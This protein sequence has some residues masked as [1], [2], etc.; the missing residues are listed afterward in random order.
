MNCAELTLIK[1]TEKLKHLPQLK[2]ILKSVRK[3]CKNQKR[4]QESCTLNYVLINKEMESNGKS[5]L[6]IVIF[7]GIHFNSNYGEKMR[8]YQELFYIIFNQYLFE[9][10]TNIQGKNMVN[11]VESTFD[12]I[13][14]STVYFLM[15]TFKNKQ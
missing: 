1:T 15:R 2:M 8:V 6:F 5:R 7:I 13:L 12:Y 10:V 9:L 11:I 4:F 3:L 14:S